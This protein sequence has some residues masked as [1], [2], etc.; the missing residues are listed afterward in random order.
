[1]HGNMMQGSGGC[2]FMIKKRT[3]YLHLAANLRYGKPLDKKISLKSRPESNPAPQIIN[4]GTFTADHSTHLGG[5][6]YYSTGRLLLGS[7]VMVHNFNASDGEDH[8]FFGGDVLA[9]YFLTKNIR[10]YN[11]TASIFWICSG[12]KICI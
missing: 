4:T 11:T 6:I 9:T 1:M 7:E 12:K 5:E 3:G 8:S 10:P 2:L